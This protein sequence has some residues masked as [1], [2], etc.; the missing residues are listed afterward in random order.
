MNCSATRKSKIICARNWKFCSICRVKICSVILDREKIWHWPWFV[1]RGTDSSCGALVLPAGVLIHSAGPWFLP[2]RPDSSTGARF[3]QRGPTSS[4]RPSSVSRG[5]ACPAG[6]DPSC[7][8]LIRHAGPDSTFGALI[9][10]EGPRFILRGPAP[11][12][13]PW[14]VPQCLD[15]E[16][17]GYWSVLWGPDSFY[18]PWSVLRGPDSSCGSIPRGPG[19]F[20]RAL[21][22]PTEPDPSRGVLKP[23]KKSTS[24]RGPSGSR[25]P[26]FGFGG[27]RYVGPRWLA[28]GGG[29]GHGPNASTPGTATAMESNSKRACSRWGI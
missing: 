1:L 16:S 3:V 13:G 27:K 10:P 8:A 19:S 2:R 7:G 6:P 24:A 14:F 5:P 4:C 26:G 21:V 22:L 15:S 25:R 23:D 20:C 18:G 11:F 29:G 9:R 17:Y 28:F 12:R